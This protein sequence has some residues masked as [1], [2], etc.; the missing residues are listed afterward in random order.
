MA[1]IKACE[2]ADGEVESEGT[3]G[4]EQEEEEV[5]QDQGLGLEDRCV[6]GF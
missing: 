2:E 5:L 3:Q 4:D 6:R 1:R